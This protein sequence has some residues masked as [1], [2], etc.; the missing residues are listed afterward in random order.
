MTAYTN[1]KETKPRTWSSSSDVMKK[2]PFGSL[3]Y[4]SFPLLTR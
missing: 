4:R 1:I 2:L 3:T